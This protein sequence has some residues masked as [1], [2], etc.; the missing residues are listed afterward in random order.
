M[1]VPFLDP[2]HDSKEFIGSLLSIPACLN[3]IKGGSSSP[4]SKNVHPCKQ[5]PTK[6]PQKIQK[7]EHNHQKY[8]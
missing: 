3:R 7:K 4:R 6:T 5:Q 2:S 1:S 8:C